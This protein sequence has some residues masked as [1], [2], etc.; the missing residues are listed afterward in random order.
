LTAPVVALE[1]APLE[2]ISTPGHTPDHLAVWNA[3]R[4]IVVS[5]DLFLGVKVRIA[6]HNESPRR[7]VQSLR[8][9]AALEPRLLLDAHRGV[10]EQ[11]TPLLR[12]KIAWME[13]TIGA[14][15]SLAAEGIGEREIRQRVLGRE[16]FTGYVSAGEYSRRAFVHAVLNEPDDAGKIRIGRE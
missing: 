3:E 9:V 7:L 10:V 11:P 1:V 14:I 5:G 2:I 13:E 16:E 15:E 4:R 12:A 6:H 8:I